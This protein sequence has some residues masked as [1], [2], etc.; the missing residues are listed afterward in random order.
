MWV[1]NEVFKTL[2]FANKYYLKRT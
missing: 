2:L 1:N